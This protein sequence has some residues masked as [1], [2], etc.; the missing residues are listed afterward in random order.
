M[1]FFDSFLAHFQK[2]PLEA[3]QAFIP[4]A[5]SIQQSLMQAQWHP[6]D[7]YHY[8]QEG[9]RKNPIIYACIRMTADGAGR[10]PI[11][12][13]VGGKKNDMHPVQ[14]LLNRPNKEHQQHSFKRELF[15]FLQLSGNV[16][17]QILSNLSQKPYEMHLLRPDRVKVNTNQAGHVAG[18][19]YHPSSTNKSVFIP[20]TH[21]VHLKYFSPDN[22]YYG[23]SPM[24]AALRVCE[25]HNKSGDFQKSLL[26]NAARPSG[27][28]VYKGNLHQPNLSAEQFNRLKQQLQEQYTGTES[29]GRPMLLEGGLEWQSTSLSPAELE[30]SQLRHNTAREIALVFGVPPMLLGIQGDNTYANYQEANRSFTRNTLLPMCE[31]LCEGLGRTLSDFYQEDITLMP[32]SDS[33]P[34]FLPEKQAQRQFI[35]NAS[36][37]SDS[38]KYDLL[39]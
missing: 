36:F 14:T 15:G 18:Y 7:Y 4:T 24:M 37:L 11:H 3:K 26:D 23:Q 27:C 1:A 30:F 39:F 29:A 21:M 22:D 10:I 17:I 28:L 20:Q 16:Y 34:A 8:C 33:L 5:L 6:H 9:Y 12:V 25:T 19:A 32:D 2:Q 35:A 31:L 38:Q 13:F